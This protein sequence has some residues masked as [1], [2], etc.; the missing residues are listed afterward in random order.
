[1]SHLCYIVTS[2]P[3][4]LSDLNPLSTPFIIAPQDWPARSISLGQRQFHFSAQHLELGFFGINRRK[5]LISI[6]VPLVIGSGE[7]QIDRLLGELDLS[8]V[9]ID[10]LKVQRDIDRVWCLVKVIP[11]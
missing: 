8:L 1:M 5:Q 10:L 3:S 11:I 4:S 7:V 6:F 9:L 2:D